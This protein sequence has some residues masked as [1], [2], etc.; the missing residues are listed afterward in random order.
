MKARNAVARLN[1]YALNPGTR[2]DK[3]RMDLNESLW[4]CT[5]KVGQAL[6]AMGHG[7]AAAYPDYHDLMA[8]LSDYLGTPE[9]TLLV[10]N[11]ADD[12]IRAIM[13]SFIEPEDAVVVAEPSFGMIDLHARVMGATIRSVPYES[14]FAYPVAGFEGALA[15]GARLAAIVRPDSPTGAVI[16]PDDLERLTAAH[17]DTIVM[18][19]ET[20]RHFLGESLLPLLKRFPNLVVLQSFSKAFGL[21]GLRLGVIAA[22]PEVITELRKVNPPFSVNAAAV[23]AGLACLD[24]LAFLDE[25]V[26]SVAREKERLRAE[27]KRRGLPVRD[28]AANFVL[29]DVGERAEAVHGDLM[30]AGIL[31]KNLDRMPL[32]RGHFRVAV[33][34]PE[35]NDRF[36]V[37][38]DAALARVAGNAT[39]VRS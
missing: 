14:D 16:A 17:P 28:S 31:V 33:G 21:A 9:E 2:R 29:V 13:Q 27:L 39:E 22:R 35:D 30:T 38:L 25:T 32:L 11:G 6:A 26:A 10:T 15:Y 23:A 18:L 7:G 5:P 36:L 24:D 3:L 20:Y 12:G 37:A 8:A 4:G 34:R 1:A 19:D